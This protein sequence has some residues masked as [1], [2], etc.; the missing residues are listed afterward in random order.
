MTPAEL[1]ILFRWTYKRLEGKG[2]GVRGKDMQ[3]ALAFYA[4]GKQREIGTQVFEIALD[5]FG[6][7]RLSSIVGELGDA[8]LKHGNDGLGITEIIG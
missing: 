7:N 1:S 5:I 2:L 4:I 6:H 8:Y 3:M